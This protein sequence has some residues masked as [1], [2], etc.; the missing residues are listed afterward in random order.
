MTNGSELDGII[1]DG[2]FPMFIADNV[3]HNLITLNGENTFHGMGMIAAVKFVNFCE[4]VLERRKVTKE[5]IM[6]ISEVPIKEYRTVNGLPKS[7]FDALKPLFSVDFMIDLLWKS[8]IKVVN[9]IPSW[10]G[11]MQV[12]FDK[13]NEF[14]QNDQILFLPIID[15]VI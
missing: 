6:Q 10:S 12:T 3:D 5:E 9:V 1:N 13:Q 15:L 11:L 2:S 14:P 8:S 7:S 4:K